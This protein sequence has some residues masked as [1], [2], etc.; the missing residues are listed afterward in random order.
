MKN[1]KLF[2]ALA[3]LLLVIA[4]LTGCTTT[5]ESYDIW[6]PTDPVSSSS[7]ASSVPSSGTPDSQ[8][9]TT[10]TPPSS[11][12]AT[13]PPASSAPET[14]PPATQPPVNNPSNLPEG[15]SLEVHFIDVGQADAIL[16]IC[17]GMTMLIDGG[18][19]ADSNLMYSYL[20]KHNITHLNYVIG[21]HA[22]ED[23][24]GGIAGALQYAT[25]DTVYCPTRSYSTQAFR[26]FVNSVNNRGASIQIPTIGLTFK[27][28]SA[29]CTV[30]AVNTNNKDLNNTSIVIRM[31]YGEKSFLFTGDAEDIVEK[32][33]LDSGVTLKSDVLK[34]GHHGS[35]SSTT[36]TFLREVM[37]EYAVICVGSDNDYGHPTSNVLSLLRDADVTTFRTDKQGDIICKSDGKTLTFTVDRN[38]NMNMYE[39]IGPNSTQQPT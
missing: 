11:T 33:L 10:V 32:K 31:V 28:G 34:V 12:P 35:N 38:A 3:S 9:G 25:V 39:K 29:V 14:Q 1:K 16:V 4:I 26:N 6:V 22:H 2:S 20:Q 21:T 23:H 24:I 5:P 27:V 18:N 36:Y 17:D 8:P 13:Q 15:S 30:L 37:P 19:R 7:T